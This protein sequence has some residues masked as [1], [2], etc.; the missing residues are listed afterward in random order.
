MSGQIPAVLD[1]MYSI[2]AVSMQR[3]GLYSIEVLVVIGATRHELPKVDIEDFAFIQG[4][5][6][7]E[8][9]QK[10]VDELWKQR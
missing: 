4:M 7:N 1:A 9:P 6:M 8:D 3:R 5:G 10:T 2:A